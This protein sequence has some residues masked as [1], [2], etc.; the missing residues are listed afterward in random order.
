MTALF[1]LALCGFLL[2]STS[3]AS[4]AFG[5]SDISA[6]RRL[7]RLLERSLETALNPMSYGIGFAVRSL[8]KSEVMVLNDLSDPIH[9]LYD[10]AKRVSRRL[11]LLGIRD[12]RGP[13]YKP[14]LEEG[15]ELSQDYMTSSN[16]KWRSVKSDK[17]DGSGVSAWVCEDPIPTTEGDTNWPVIKASATI[18]GITPKEL[19]KLLMDSSSVTKYNQFATSREDVEELMSP[20]KGVVEKVV[21]AKTSNPFKI[22]PYDFVSLM[23][24]APVG[25]QGGYRIITRGCTHA[26]APED[27]NYQRSHI[28]LGVNDLRKSNTGKGTVITNIQQARYQALPRWFL[29]KMNTAGTVSYVVALKAFVEKGGK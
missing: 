27:S 19:C 9:Y 3:C 12:W 26:K 20:K 25:K 16:I 5:R 13:E 8:M 17:S 7:E 2:L 28:I 22:K 14:L 15:I 6:T 1:V 18:Q 24:S 11:R 10:K 4:S 21:W 29:M 23:R